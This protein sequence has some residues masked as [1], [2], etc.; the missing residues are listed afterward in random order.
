[1]EAE[2]GRGL[3]RHRRVIVMEDN[4]S[5]HNIPLHPTRFYAKDKAG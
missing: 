3:G 1:M 2:K 5:S 4:E